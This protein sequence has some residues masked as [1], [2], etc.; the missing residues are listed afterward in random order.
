[1]YVQWFVK[2][3]GGQGRPGT[4]GVGRAEAFAMIADGHGVLSNWWRTKPNGCISP[5]EVQE[6]LNEHNLDRHVHDYD[7][8]GPQSPFISLASGAVERDT[9]LQRNFI[10][11]AIDTAL[12]FATDSW[13]RPGALFY[14]W[15]LVGLNPAVGLSVVAEEIRELNA[16]R[17]W[18]PFQLEGEITAKIH[19]PANQISHV[20]WW[21]GSVDVSEPIDR[22]SNTNFM[23]PTPILNARDRF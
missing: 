11:S 21:D 22:Y 14:G 6:M 9:A 10:Y 15:V 18:S 19:I 5:S 1:M 13:D 23:E 3:I 16:Y 12:E 2:G 8:F 17:R 20:E 7:T 4:S